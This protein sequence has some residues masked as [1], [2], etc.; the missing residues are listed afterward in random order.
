M[1]LSILNNVSDLTAENALSNTQMN[2]QKSL[3]QLSTGLR[4][5][6]G[7]DDSAGMSIASGMNANIAAL[8]QSQQNASNGVG[9]LQTADGALSQVTTLLNRAVT[10]ATEGSNSGITGS[11]STALNNEFKSIM[12]E[13]DQIGATTNFNGQNVFASNSPTTF[14]STQGSVGSPLSAATTLTAGSKTTISDSATGGTFVFT[15]AGGDTLATLSTAIGNAVTAGTLS[16]GTALTFSAGQAQI[17]GAATGINVTSNDASLGAFNA[18]AGASSTNT[19]FISDSSTANSPTNTQIQTTISALSQTQLS[20]NSN[21][22]TSATNSQTALTAINAAI[23]SISAQRGVIGASVNRLN[24]ASTVMAAQVTNL[25]SAVNSVQ[26]ADIGK[27]VANMT[28][29]NILQS[30]G[31]AALQ[32]ANQAQQ[33]VLKLVQ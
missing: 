26:N 17:A 1:T 20:L 2:L 6:S 3:T 21:N 23:T 31:M 25:Q 22:L 29:Y 12:S 33:A 7:S 14:T 24:A 30:T 16:A 10:L 32:Q 5:N 19:V 15:A 28:Q 13:V 27:T 18:V 11:Q 9:L 4:I 8:T